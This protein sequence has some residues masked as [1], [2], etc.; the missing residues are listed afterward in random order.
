MIKQAL[1]TMMRLPFAK[2][3]VPASI[4]RRFTVS[5]RAYTSDSDPSFPAPAS[6]QRAISKYAVYKG[7]AAMQMGLI[8]PTWKFGPK[9]NGLAILDREGVVLLEFASS[10]SGGNGVGDRSYDWSSKVNFALK[11]TELG[12]FLDEKTLNKGFELFHDPGKGGENEGQQRKTLK[13]QTLPD[14]STYMIS[15]SQS[16]K[17]GGK[18]NV[19]VPVTGNEMQVIKHLVI[20]ALPR[21]TGFDMV[22]DGFHTMGGQG[23]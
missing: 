12:N 6:N 3:V 5:P 4:G 8:G 10:N 18:S 19:S 2:P 7:K 13:V 22:C 15:V 16:D 9:G 17:A 14:G 21:L 20:Y 23:N 1:S 11:A